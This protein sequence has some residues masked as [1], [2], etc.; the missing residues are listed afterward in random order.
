[1]RV[2]LGSP[3]VPWFPEQ[4]TASSVPSPRDNPEGA[5]NEKLLAFPD[6]SAKLLAKLRDSYYYKVKLN[7]SIAQEAGHDYAGNGGIHTN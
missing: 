7:G 6:G 5:P 3:V 1:M 2:K 4:D